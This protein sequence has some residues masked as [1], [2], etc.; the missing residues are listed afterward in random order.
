[1]NGFE[2]YK[3]FN[4]FN[5]HFNKNSSYDYHKYH[6]SIR[7]S[8]EKFKSSKF[9][10]QFETLAKHLKERNLSSSLILYRL[11]KSY[12]FSYV[13]LTFRTINV[14]DSMMYINQVELHQVESDMIFLYENYNTN[15]HQ[16]TECVDNIYPI[17]YNLYL[18]ESICLETLILY[19]SY[20][21][22]Y[23][24]RESSKDSIRWPSELKKFE[25]VRG[26]IET[27]IPRTLFNDFVMKKL[28]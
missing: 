19:D 22:K 21:K 14:I 16:L 26:F 28:V 6:G 23:L 8:E 24:V 12:E 4:A 5:L 1:M 13:P 3:M 11:F 9:R 10:W 7:I 20:I 18:D 27:I 25:K 17:L 2:L 15:L